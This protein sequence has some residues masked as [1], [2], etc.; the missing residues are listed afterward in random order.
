MAHKVEKLLTEQMIESVSVDN[1][2]EYYFSTTTHHTGEQYK[3]F[4]TLRIYLRQHAAEIMTKNEL[5][6]LEF[7]QFQSILPILFTCQTISLCLDIIDQYIRKDLDNRIQH[8]FSLLR[9]AQ[10]ILKTW[11]PIEPTEHNCWERRGMAR[12]L[13]QISF[14]AKVQ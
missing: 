11:K 9:T 12:I 3:N 13:I 1:I 6:Q 8:S 4:T 2:L 5:F 14:S 7:E 10:M